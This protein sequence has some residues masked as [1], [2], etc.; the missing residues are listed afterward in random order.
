MLSISLLAFSHVCIVCL[1]HFRVPGSPVPNMA[2]TL[3]PRSA[4]NRTAPRPM[5]APGGTK[6]LKQVRA[7]DMDATK[8]ELRQLLKD[9]HESLLQQVEL[10]RLRLEDDHEYR[11]K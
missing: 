11:V 1:A 4:L 9:E 10:A 5:T 8:G 7:L 2:G 3:R 6:V